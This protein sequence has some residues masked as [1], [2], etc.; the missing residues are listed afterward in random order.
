MYSFNA[1]AICNKDR[2]E[3]KRTIVS[4]DGSTLNVA[5]DKAERKTAA[6]Y[7]NHTFTLTMGNRQPMH[8]RPAVREAEAAA[9][10]QGVKK[11]A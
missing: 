9:A 1:T 11:A 4:A 5:W 8:L 7:P 3:V 6:M 2:R 10:A